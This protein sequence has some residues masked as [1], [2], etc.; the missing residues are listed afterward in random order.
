MSLFFHFDDAIRQYVD[1]WREDVRTMEGKEQ[2]EP[3]I[4]A[5][6]R[7][8]I[9]YIYLNIYQ[10]LNIYSR[11]D[12]DPNLVMLSFIA[13]TTSMSRLFEDSTSIRDT[14]TRLLMLNHGT[15]GLLDRENDAVLIWWRG[16]VMSKAIGDS[17]LSQREIES[18]VD[19]Q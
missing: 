13:A 16:Q 8:A 15:Y 18:I 3:P 17:W 9:G 6:G 2:W 4:D 1:E 7:V 19:P 11:K 14:F 5:Q 10:D 12:Y